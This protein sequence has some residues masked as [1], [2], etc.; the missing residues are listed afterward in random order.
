MAVAPHNATRE[1]RCRERNHKGR[2]AA[3]RRRIMPGGNDRGANR[4]PGIRVERAVVVIVTLDE[5]AVDDVGI[6]E[7]L[8]NE[9]AESAGAPVQESDTT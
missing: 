7:L 9:H 3:N 8:D 4:G 6:T 5:P 2:S 1:R